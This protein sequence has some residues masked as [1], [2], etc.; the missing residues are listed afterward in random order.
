MRYSFVILH[1]MAAD[2]TVQCISS[3]LALKKEPGDEL[4]IYVVDNASPD[5]S[6]RKLLE[7]YAGNDN[8]KVLLCREN[9]G[10]ARGNNIGF[11]RARKAGTDFLIM[12]NNDTEI[13]DPCFL[14]KIK[15]MY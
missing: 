10:F 13:E 7:R 3:I 6:G 8:V 14:K 5:G 2:Y 15:E 12:L 4:M 1:Y 11:R 9:I